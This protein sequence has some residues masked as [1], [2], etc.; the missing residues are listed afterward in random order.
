[1][2][3]FG[4]RMNIADYNELEEDSSREKTADHA[5]DQ[6]IFHLIICLRE[7]FRNVGMPLKLNDVTSHVLPLVTSIFGHEHIAVVTLIYRVTS[8]NVCFS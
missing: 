1:M 7:H 5:A 3:R 8:I 2:S 4:N 6:V